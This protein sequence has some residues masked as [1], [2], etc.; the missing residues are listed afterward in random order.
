MSLVQKNKK[1]SG[2]KVEPI[3]VKNNKIVK[4]ATVKKTPPTK[5]QSLFQ[6]KILAQKAKRAA[7]EK[8]K[9]QQDQMEEN[10][11]FQREQSMLQNLIDADEEDKKHMNNDYFAMRQAT[12]KETAF[13]DM[14]SDQQ[15][16]IS[17][18]ILKKAKKNW[19]S[20]LMPGS[21]LLGVQG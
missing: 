4:P 11:K 18:L 7:E 12:A 17:S 16:D 14:K 8:L 19:F 6:K 20:G 15:T 2:F 21:E 10:D 9:K 1:A 13:A 5:A 3:V